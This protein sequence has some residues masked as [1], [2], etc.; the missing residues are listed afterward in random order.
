MLL[1]SQLWSCVGEVFKIVLVEREMTVISGCKTGLLLS[2]LRVKIV[3]ILN[4]IYSR[5]ERWCDLSSVQLLPV[6][7]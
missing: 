3:H 4:R 2:E 7:S 5:Y 1:Q 6:K